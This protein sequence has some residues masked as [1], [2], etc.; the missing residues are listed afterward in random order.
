MNGSIHVCDDPVA[1]H[2]Q[3]GKLPARSGRLILVGWHHAIDPAEAIVPPS[4]VRA[5]ASAMTS[6]ARVTFFSSEHSAEQQRLARSEWSH[7]E[8]DDVRAIP[9]DGWRDRARAM[10]GGMP[11]T[12]VQLSTVRAHVAE[13]FFDDADYPLW[14]RAQVA[15]LS[16]PASPP[17]VV[18]RKTLLA[19]IDE[20]WTGRAG[21][22]ADQ[23][24]LGILRPGVDGDML[25]FLSLDD[26]FGAAFVEAMAV[27]IQSAGFDWTNVGE[28]DF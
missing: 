4:L 10:L 15:L 18:D 26:A 7:V 22:L 23:G 27:A 24:V 21:L 17:P 12:I 11:A 5:M 19:L 6:V 28:A 20:D 14:L 13:R 9:A 2:W 16:A 8:G 3:L 25:G 1:A